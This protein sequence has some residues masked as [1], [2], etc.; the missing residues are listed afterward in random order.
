MIRDILV[1]LP[2]WHGEDKS[3]A[4]AKVNRPS[5]ST[6]AKRRE[7]L[8]H[9]GLPESQFDRPHIP[10][11]MDIYTRTPKEIAFAIM[12]KVVITQRAWQPDLAAKDAITS[13]GS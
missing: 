12:A 11:G 7:R 4:F 5:I 13:C 8:S 6:Q 9:E 10:I 1:D 2:H 3:I